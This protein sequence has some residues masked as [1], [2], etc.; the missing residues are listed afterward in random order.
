MKHKYCVVW[1]RC[2]CER[3]FQSLS[4]ESSCWCSWRS[5][6]WRMSLRLRPSS[7]ILYKIQ[8]AAKVFY[9]YMW[10]ILVWSQAAIWRKRHDIIV[11]FEFL[12]R[13]LIYVLFVIPVPVCKL[14]YEDEGN[15]SCVEE[16]NCYFDCDQVVQGSAAKHTPPTLNV[17]PP[18][19]RG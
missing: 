7:T 6:L 12:I 2:S 1:C 19:K 5:D 10:C 8:N 18:L 11:L 15:F 3:S 13:F 16:S 14:Q 17:P 4:S 9:F